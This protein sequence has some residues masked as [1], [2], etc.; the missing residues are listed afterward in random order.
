MKLPGNLLFFSTLIL[1]LTFYGYNISEGKNKYIKAEDPVRVDSRIVGSRAVCLNGSFIFVEYTTEAA[2]DDNVYWSMRDATGF[3]VSSPRGPVVSIPYTSEGAFTLSLRISR[4]GDSNFYTETID[5]VVERGPTFILQPDVVLCGNENVTLTALDP[6]DPNLANFT[7]EWTDLAGNPIGSGNSIVTNTPGRY[8]VYVSSVACQV[9]GS[10][11]VGPS[12][13]VELT[14]S[15]TNACLGETVIFTPDVPVNGLWSYQKSDQV[16]RTELGNFFELFLDTEDLDGLGDYTIFF[17]VEDTERPGC[18]VEKQR[19]LTV[20][21][22]ASFDIIDITDSE[23][24]DNPTGEFKIIAN[25]GMQTVS[26]AGPREFSFVNVF[27]ETVLEIDGLEPGIYTITGESFGCILSSTVTIDNINPDAGI[28]FTVTS[29]NQSCSGTGIIPGKIIITVEDTSQPLNYRIVDSEGIAIGGSFGNQLSVSVDVPAGEYQVEVSDADNCGSVNAETYTVS[30]SGQVNFSVPSSITACE[31]YDLVP[32][33][34]QSLRYELTGPDGQQIIRDTDNGTFRISS[35]GSYEILAISEDSDSPLCPN[36]KSFDV[37]INDQIEFDYSQR[38]ID[39]L[40]N[41]IY[42]AELL[43][44]DPSTVVIRWLASD[45]V[46]I[47]GR[48]PDFFPPSVGTFY[49]DVQPRASSQCPAAPIPFEVTAV[50]REV[51][52]EIEGTPFCGLDPFTTL[53]VVTDFDVIEFIE[54][55]YIDED[56][57]YIHLENLQNMESIDIADEGT[58]EVVVRN[59]IY[60]EMGRTTFEVG[61][62]LEITLSMSAKQY[63]CIEENRYNTLNPGEFA[64]YIWIKEGEVLSTDATFTPIETGV[65]EL[66]V[67]DLNGCPVSTE[68]EVEDICAQL[69]SMP[70]AMVPGD[71]NRDFRVYANPAISEVEVFV[72]NKLGELIFHCQSENNLDTSA[73]CIWDGFVNGTKLMVGTYPVTIKYKVPSINLTDQ[74]NSFIVVPQ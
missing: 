15:A 56:D 54:W 60:C 52:V 32:Q 1:I 5:V 41:Q 42:T 37:V 69:I 29:D 8:I 40:G 63:I 73:I 71:L 59:D 35:S 62:I 74:Y 19:N 65:Y 44:M 47:L 28:P 26:I 34:A 39:C 22:N 64:S 2:P 33:G 67:V 31:F 72:F 16:T 4:G 50:Q 23:S 66:E 21:E 61:R 3:E 18:S 17:N 58:Y 7:I 20:R 53:T 12:L 9:A 51:E 46:T 43:G 6:N 55:Y 38:Q 70:T 45:N 49:L 36:L 25:T 13:E 48:D 57:N 68:F 24:C 11:F 30:G 14:Q 27:P 10:T